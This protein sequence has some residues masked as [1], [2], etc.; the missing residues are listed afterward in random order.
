MLI[1]Y[2]SWHTFDTTVTLSNSV[3]IETVSKIT[4][5]IDKYKLHGITQEF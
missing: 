3:S 5:H 2:V 4:C 1:K